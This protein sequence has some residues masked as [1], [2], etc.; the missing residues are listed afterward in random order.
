MN[1]V[2]TLAAAD[3][4]DLFNET[5]AQ[6]GLPGALVEK[7]FWVSWTLLQLFT[8]EELKG[9]VVFKGGTALSKVFNAIRRFSEDVDLIID[10]RCSASPATPTRRRRLRSASGASSSRRCWSP[11]TRSSR[12]RSSPRCEAAS[13]P[14][15][16]PAV[17][18]CEHAAE[19]TAVPL[20]SSSTR[21]P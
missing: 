5:G 12:E 4:A 1:G 19:P 2:A 14:S 6:S 15:W 10:S 13:R 11:A 21:R 17:G 3:R 18:N 20:W 9:H 16:D 7:D 8:M